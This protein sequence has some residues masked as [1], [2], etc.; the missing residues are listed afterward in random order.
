MSCLP[1][2]KII[3]KNR[4]SGSALGSYH[5]LPGGSVCDCW[6]PILSGPPHWH[7]Q[8]N[9]GPRLGMRKKI[10]VPP[11]PLQKK[12]WSPSVKED[13]VVKKFWSGLVSSSENQGV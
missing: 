6:L 5:F 1:E 2:Y 11:L 10:L 7:A 13:H 12:F 9:S 3:R 8:K 4:A